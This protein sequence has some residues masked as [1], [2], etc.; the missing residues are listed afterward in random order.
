[1]AVGSWHAAVLCVCRS[2]AY[3]AYSCV[4]VPPLVLML[5]CVCAHVM[6]VCVCAQASPRLVLDDEAAKRMTARIQDAGTEVSGEV[7]GLA[8]AQKEC[9]SPRTFQR[10]CRWLA[11]SMRC[12]GGKQRSLRL[13]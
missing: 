11:A 13:C 1:M 4:G 2:T 12:M 8:R 6:C 3:M 7:G 9:A 10:A 5:V